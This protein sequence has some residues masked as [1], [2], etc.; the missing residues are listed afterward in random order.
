METRKVV[1]GLYLL[2]YDAVISLVHS[3]V[4][5]ASQKLNEYIFPKVKGL[6]GTAATTI[7]GFV[8]TPTKRVYETIGNIGEA[9]RVYVLYNYYLP[10]GLK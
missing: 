3:A 7:K 6:D 10:L 2:L 4:H 1:R 5:V 9:R 8:R